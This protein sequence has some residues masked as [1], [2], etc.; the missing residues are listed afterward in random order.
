MLYQE[1]GGEPV[2]PL[3]SW[4][5]LTINSACDRAD[6]LMD[7]LEKAFGKLFNLRLEE[8]LLAEDRARLPSRPANRPFKA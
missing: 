2:G 1:K 5:Q 4:K 3:L 8:N 6:E 7:E